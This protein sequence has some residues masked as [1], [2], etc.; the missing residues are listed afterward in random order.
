MFGSGALTKYAA[1]A[2]QER[3]ASEADE[4]HDQLHKVCVC[5]HA[6]VRA[7]RGCSNISNNE[8]NIAVFDSLF[9]TE[10]YCWILRILFVILRVLLR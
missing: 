9:Y 4:M 3:A 8:W 10:G 5:V 7:Y 2:A 6:R 1:V